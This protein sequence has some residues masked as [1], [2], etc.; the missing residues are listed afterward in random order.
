METIIVYVDDAEYARPLL[1][2]AAGNP[3]ARHTHW[4]LVA[5]AP[6]VT[7]RVSKF[8]S[9]RAREQWRNKWADK[10]FD[11]CVPILADSGAHTTT[12]LA[13]GPLQALLPELLEAHGQHAQV[14]DLRRPK[15]AEH[16]A[17]ALAPAAVEGGGSLRKL[18]GVLAGIGALWTV[19][20]GEVLAA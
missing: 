10:L 12:V 2:A 6:R 8:V 20:V 17:P 9:N 11:A 19:V 1:Q 4:V 5:C 3:N 16:T 7:H 13:K 18:G 14:V 15:M